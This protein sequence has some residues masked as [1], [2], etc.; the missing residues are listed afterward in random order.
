MVELSVAS[1][2]LGITIGFILFPTVIYFVRELYLKSKNKR[3][4]AGPVKAGAVLVTGSNSGI[5][6]MMVAELVKNN[7]HVFAGVRSAKKGKG[8]EKKH[9]K[10]AVTHVI[11]DVSEPSTLED[12][13]ELMREAID[14]NEACADGLVAVVNCAGIN[15]QGPLEFQPIDQFA[16]VLNVNVTGQIAVTQAVL[17]LLRTAKTPGRV[18]F[19]GSGAGFVAGSMQGAYCASKYAL[20]AVA[21]CLRRELSAWD[22]SVSLIQAGQFAT[23][24]TS[25]Y[26][27]EKKALL[28]TPEWRDTNAD[29]FYG[30][31]YENSLPQRSKWFGKPKI[32]KRAIMDAITSKYPQTRYLVGSPL[33]MSAVSMIYA[34][35]WFIPDR[36]QDAELAPKQWPR[37]QKKWRIPSIADLPS[38]Q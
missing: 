23:T 28:H 14:T 5:G 4:F 18:V 21:D 13:V 9:P 7:F 27:D 10:G 15:K 36:F 34:I 1:I 17:P 24:L 8:V 6:E 33:F 19:L 32:I 29:H 35:K 2:I 31:Y 11:M 25:T 12:A 3:K 26:D 30:A 20:E 37:R 22:M 16:S 38:G